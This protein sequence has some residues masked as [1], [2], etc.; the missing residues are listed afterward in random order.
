[1][2]TNPLFALRGDAAR[3]MH[4]QGFI[5][6]VTNVIA[7]MTMCYSGLN[8]YFDVAALLAVAL[9]LSEPQYW[10]VVYGSWKEAYTVRRFW[11]CEQL[12]LLVNFNDS[13][14]RL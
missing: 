9:G 2:A 7:Y 4:S 5:L 8:I 11:R 14:M 6:M 13:L 3:S 1:M 12:A 10:P